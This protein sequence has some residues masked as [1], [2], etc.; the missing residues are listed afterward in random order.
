[1]NWTEYGR[2]RGVWL[3]VFTLSMLFTLA[4]SGRA[5]AQSSY[6]IT[7]LGTLGGNNSIPY[8]ITN[9]GEVVG[10]SDTGQFDTSGNPIDH[11]F[12]WVGGRM[13]DLNTLGGT[14]SS[15]TGAN[16][17]GQAAGISDVTSGL[18]SHAVLWS[19][20]TMTDLGA[21]NGPNGYSFAQLINAEG[22]V[23]GGS[24]TADGGFDAVVW[25]HGA[26]SDLGTLPCPTGGC[27][28]FANGINDL[29][30]IVGG[31]QVS[32]VPDPTLGFPPY[33]AALWSRREILDLGAGPN[34]S[35]GSVAFN[36]NNRRQVVGR[37]APPDPIEGA[38]AHAFLWESGIMHDLGVPAELGD[39]NSEANSLNDSGQIVG[40]SGVGF[41]ESYSPDHALLWQSGHWTDLNTLIPGDSGYYLIVAFDVNARGQI[42]V[43]A[44]QASTGNIHAAVLTPQPSGVDENAVS[45]AA[46]VSTGAPSISENARRL[47]ILA[48][49]R[50]K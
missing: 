25:H 6:T 38:V 26:I 12:R 10:V 17:A 39:D 5:G 18:T 42:V 15:A 41:I 45:S 48:R 11:A 8:W 20:G 7:D 22:Q 43:C 31:S 37:T 19:A 4:T 36:I 23:A 9:R 40:D 50:K 2:A 28:S 29:G 13:Q 1:M 27:Q 46:R 3:S 33:H 49:K 30:Q 21:L 44:V 14:N 24:T 35:L 47:L 16:A 34:G 32:D